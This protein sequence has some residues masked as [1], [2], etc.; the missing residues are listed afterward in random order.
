M[1]CRR[2][3]TSEVVCI[4][5]SLAPLLFSKNTSNSLFMKLIQFLGGYLLQDDAKNHMVL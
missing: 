5:I 2:E 1:Y 3:S 4:Q